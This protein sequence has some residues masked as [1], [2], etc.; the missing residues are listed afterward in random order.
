M[1]DHRS[2]EARFMR[3]RR[4]ELVAHCGGAPSQTQRVMIE[5]AVWLSL[6]IALL[7][8][9]QAEMGD[10]TEHDSK[11]YLAWVGS[12]TRLMK[13]LGPPAVSN[14]PPQSRLRAYL[15]GPAAS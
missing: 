11:T 12:L 9:K 1:L 3:D 6:R 2:R 4:A 14:T 10:M 7:D 13:D 5:R 15:D 8:R